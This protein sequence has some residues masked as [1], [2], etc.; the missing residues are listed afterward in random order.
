MGYLFRADNPH[1]EGGTVTVTGVMAFNPST[2]GRSPDCF[3]YYGSL[4]YG[5]FTYEVETANVGDSCPGMDY[6]HP[7]VFLNFE[8]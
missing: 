2:S 5:D 6:L 7:I 1:L 3:V 8:A 4:D